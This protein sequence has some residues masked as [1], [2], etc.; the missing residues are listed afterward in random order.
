MRRGGEELQL[1]IGWGDEIVDADGEIPDPLFILRQ[2][3]KPER[4]DIDVPRG[5]ERHGKLAAGMPPGQICIDAGDVY[6]LTEGLHL[7]QPLEIIDTHKSSSAVTS[8][9]VQVPQRQ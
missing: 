6:A 9:K 5:V 7:Q 1:L 3:Q 2:I 8:G 4:L